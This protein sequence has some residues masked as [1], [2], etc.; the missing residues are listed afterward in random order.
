MTEGSIHEIIYL[1]GTRQVPPTAGITNVISSSPEDLKQSHPKRSY[2]SV[3]INESIDTN[4]SDNKRS[5][6]SVLTNRTI[7]IDTGNSNE[8]EM[9][10]PLITSPKPKLPLKRELKQ[11]EKWEPNFDTSFLDSSDSEDS[12][13]LEGLAKK[14]KNSHYFDEKEKIGI[15]REQ[16]KKRRYHRT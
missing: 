2:K 14:R 15:G 7:H 10:I 4:N 3:L 6:K 16:D 11:K 5:Y 12:L 8:K 13:D 1:D 9:K